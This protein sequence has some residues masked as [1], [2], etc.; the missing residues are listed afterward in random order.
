MSRRAVATGSSP[1]RDEVPSNL[2]GAQIRFARTALG[3]TLREL[4]EAI[5][6]SAPYLCDIERGFRGPLRP[7][8]LTLVAEAIRISRVDLMA[9]AECDVL[10]RWR[11]GRGV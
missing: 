10:A 3:V 1:D 8:L 5:G 2:C 9:L 11:R 6:V 7:E 4:A